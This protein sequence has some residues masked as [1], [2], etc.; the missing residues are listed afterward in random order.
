MITLQGSINELR[1]NLRS[2][3]ASH[4]VSTLNS[5]IS[6]FVVFT[7]YDKL[8]PLFNYWMVW[9]TDTYGSFYYIYWNN[10]YYEMEII[11]KTSNAIS[12]T[13][14]HTIACKEINICYLLTSVIMSHSSSVMVEHW[15]FDAVNLASSSSGIYLK[16][17]HEPI[18]DKSDSSMSIIKNSIPAA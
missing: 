2:I 10:Y 15:C 3:F 18:P 8:F 12:R 13:R 9:R 17:C 7:I 4:F 16:T 6:N 14:H 1:E 11:K 5:I